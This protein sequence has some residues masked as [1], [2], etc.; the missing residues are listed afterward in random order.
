MDKKYNDLVMS[1][2]FMEND[3]IKKI[4]EVNNKYLK[5][6]DLEKAIR[7]YFGSEDGLESMSWAS[8][9][10]SLYHSILSQ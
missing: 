4:E 8:I 1:I 9:I 3:L 5:D 2:D 10:I 6:K 7:K